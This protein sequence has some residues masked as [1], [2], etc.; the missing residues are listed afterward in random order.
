MLS[1]IPPILFKKVA[2]TAFKQLD[3]IESDKNL[4][5]FDTVKDV[6]LAAVKKYGC[7]LGWGSERLKDDKEV[8]LVAVKEYGDALYCASERLKDNKE[9][10]LA[11]V[12]QYRFALIYASEELKNDKE[13]KD[14]VPKT[15]QKKKN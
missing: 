5:Y 15:D 12:K 4:D 10:V 13:K 8:V 7:A 14:S 6:F 2:F 1:S 3:Y 9:V 11:A